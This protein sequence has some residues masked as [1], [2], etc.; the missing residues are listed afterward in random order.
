MVEIAGCDGY[1]DA[2]VGRVVERAGVSRAT[3]YRHFVSREGCFLAAYREIATRLGEGLRGACLARPP[4]ERLPVALDALLSAFA[5]HPAAARMLLVEAGGVSP[6]LRVEH[7]RTLVSFESSLTTGLLAGSGAPRAPRITA[8]AALGAVFGVLSVRVLEGGVDALPELRSE[9]LAWLDAYALDPGCA[10][11][12]PDWNVL[13]RA[14]PWASRPADD[15]L[16]RLLPRGR[17]ALQQSEA[18]ARRR[19]RILSAIARLVAEKGYAATSVADVVVVARV[20]RSAFYSHFANKQDAFLAAQMVSLQEGIAVAAAEFS[21]V[22]SWPEQV[23]RA[24]E[25]MLTYVTAHPSL[26]AL[27][28]LEAAAAGP[29]AIKRQRDSRMAYALFLERGYRHGERAARLP[30]ICSEAIAAAVFALMRRQ[31]LLRHT[32]RILVLLPQVVYVIL[33]PFI[34]PSFAR[35]FVVARARAA[36]PAAQTG[37]P[38][39]PLSPAPA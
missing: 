11:E 30:P 15:P 36:A 35:E 26:A 27:G 19:E 16:P 34:G 23:W 29:A 33:A 39:G 14:L 13:G 3:F 31:V 20:T 2:S 25:A 8:C 12:E 37:P 18:A 22:S 7:E 4:D 24:C 1:P 28:I 5:A 6:A 9:L 17:S 38:S 10:W 21:V 32:T